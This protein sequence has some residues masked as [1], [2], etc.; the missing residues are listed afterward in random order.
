MTQIQQDG[1]F[2]SVADNSP[3]LFE[4]EIENKMDARHFRNLIL[5][6]PLALAG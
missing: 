3:E 2:M 5:R 6:V 1:L 4:E